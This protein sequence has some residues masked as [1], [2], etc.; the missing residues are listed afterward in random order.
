VIKSVTPRHNGRRVIAGLLVSLLIATVVAD[1]QIGVLFSPLLIL[2]SLLS[3]D[4]RVEAALIE[5]V[6]ALGSERARTNAGMRLAPTLRLALVRLRL[7]VSPLG[8]RA[9]PLPAN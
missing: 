5:Y 8:S 7:D 4:P 6:R 3:I 2:V 1:F 9:P